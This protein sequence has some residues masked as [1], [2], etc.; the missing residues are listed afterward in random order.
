MI[1]RSVV[2]ADDR[3]STLCK[4]LHRHHEK[5]HDTAHDDHRAHI[6]V[7]AVC[8]ERLVEGNLDEAFGTLHDKR[9]HPQRDRTPRDLRVDTQIF[10]LKAQV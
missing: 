4:A 6:E 3:L 5:L 8:G 9:R 10:F 2:I 7:A 1:A